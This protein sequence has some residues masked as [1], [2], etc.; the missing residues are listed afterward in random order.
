[1]AAP[2]FRIHDSFGIDCCYLPSHQ[3]V[4]SAGE[5]KKK[6]KKREEKKAKW[7]GVVCRNWRLGVAWDGWLYFMEMAKSAALGT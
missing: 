5:K 4:P 2:V 3:P 1:M 6:R 7:I